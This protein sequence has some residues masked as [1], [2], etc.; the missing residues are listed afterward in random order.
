[1]HE[2]N[3]PEVR[4]FPQSHTSSVG[5]AEDPNR[6][7]MALNLMLF[8][9]SSAVQVGRRSAGNV[10]LRSLPGGHLGHDSWIILWQV[11]GIL[12]AA[13]S[14]LRSL[15]LKGCGLKRTTRAAHQ[16][17]NDLLGWQW[18]LQPQSKG[19]PGSGP[20]LALGWRFS[21]G[22]L[23]G[24]GGRK[25]ARLDFEHQGWERQQRKERVKEREREREC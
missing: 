25:S 1:M 5:W 20:A 12:F 11:C 17:R 6:V 16:A 14:L 10:G 4:L 19:T 22:S 21:P 8:A 15:N 18:C 2:D 23:Q 9:L 13:L 3:G 7:W 24:T